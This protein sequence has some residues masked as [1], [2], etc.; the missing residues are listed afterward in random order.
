MSIHRHVL[1]ASLVVWSFS[2]PSWAQSAPPAHDWSHAT[3]LNAFAGVMGDSSQVVPALGGA[4]GWEMTPRIALE[5]AASWL[6]RGNG[7]DGFTAAL[8]IQSALLPGRKAVPF[9][10][11]G[12]GLHRATFD[13]IRSTIPDF[14]QRRMGHVR[15]EGVM[16]TFT[17]PSIV[18][19]GGVNVFLTRHVVLRPDV[20]VAVV[21]RDSDHYLTATAALHLAYRF[22]HHPVTAGRAR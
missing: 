11:A 7:A 16:S 4:L 2:I 1:W 8:T 6:D 21:V 12:I 3:T 22:E 13:R 17:D 15:M 19:G 20:V 5:G 9:V 10:Q 18:F 14:Y